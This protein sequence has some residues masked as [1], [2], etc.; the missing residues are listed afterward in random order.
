M[1]WNRSTVV[2]SE[3]TKEETRMTVTDKTV[4]IIDFSLSGLIS[5]LKSSE[6]IKIYLMFKKAKLLNLFL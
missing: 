6:L 5:T 1:S 3:T 2:R 4:K